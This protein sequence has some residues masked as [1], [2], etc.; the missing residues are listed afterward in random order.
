MLV[1]SFGLGSFFFFSSRRRHTILQGDCSS[2]VC[3]FFSS[4]RRHTRLQGDCSS[5][6]CSSDLYDST[7]LADNTVWSICEN[8][9]GTLWVGTDKGG[10]DRYDKKTQ[11]FQHYRHNEADP[12]SI[13][14]NTVRA[15]C[16]GAS[17]ELWIATEQDGLNRFDSSRKRF[18]HFR[19]EPADSFGISHNFINALY[20]D[21]DGDLWV[22][23]VS[24]DRYDRSTGRF[25]HYDSILSGTAFFKTV[26]RTATQIQSLAEDHSGRLWIAMFPMGLF[27][28][29][30]KTNAI[31]SYPHPSASYYVHVDPNGTV[32]LGSFGHGLCRYNASTDRFDNFTE[33]DGLP[34]NFVKG[35]LSEDRGN[36]WLSTSKGL[37]R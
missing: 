28:L 3:F 11:R 18:V 25:V 10:L 12:R 32:W 8:R 6:V 14:S 37:S 34:S 13:S 26:P 17:G 1:C 2:Y 21:R 36:L 22:G 7:T 20:L 35:I 33:L 5:D 27:R 24:L 30:K 31:V 23:G 29:D 19:H 15:I 4:R 16:E 9:N